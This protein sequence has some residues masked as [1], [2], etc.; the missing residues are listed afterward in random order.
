M[1]T[2]KWC[3]VVNVRDCGAAEDDPR[4]GQECKQPD[5]QLLN[6]VASWQDNRVIRDILP[7][8]L[9]IKPQLPQDASRVSLPCT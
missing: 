8:D 7:G 9:K 2:T 3:E 1:I 5:F 4:I 6:K